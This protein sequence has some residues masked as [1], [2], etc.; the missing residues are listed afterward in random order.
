MTERVV[1][2]MRKISV[3][4]TVLIAV[5]VLAFGTTKVYADGYQVYISDDAD[6]LTDS[7]EM[8]LYTYMEPITKY[9]N[10]AFKTIDSNRY[11]TATYADNYYHQLFGTASGTLFIID[12]DNREIYIF[13]DGAIY[14][15]ITKSYAN[16]I[17]DNVYKLATNGDYLA[18]AT[19]TF[20]QINTLLDGGHIAQPMKFITNGLLALILAFIINFIIIK[21]K[22]QKAKTTNNELLRSIF[23]KCEVY[24]ANQ[25]FTHQTKVYDPPSSS[26]GS[27]GGGG[28]GGGGHS[29]GGGGHGF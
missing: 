7:E 26:G 14:K 17:T 23:S 5:W 29:G 6:L 15:R 19:K 4:L 9:G 11:S 13:S 21:A 24:N 3:I 28:G 2:T 22:A 25:V 20:T 12:M 27:G 8:E 1:M 10:V 16:T 18:C